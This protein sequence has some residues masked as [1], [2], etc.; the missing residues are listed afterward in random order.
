MGFK[1]GNVARAMNAI[2]A[3]LPLT[4][5]VPFGLQIYSCTQPGVIAPGFD[6]GPWIYSE[7]ILNRYVVFER[8]LNHMNVNDHDC[9]MQAAGFKAT[10]FING[11][12]KGN[13]Y[14]YNSTL[15]RMISMGHQIGSHT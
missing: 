7:D 13:I 14:D 2:A 1:F 12:N 11:A 4:F 6:D 5:A 10:W 8:L 15:Q 9:S 3:L